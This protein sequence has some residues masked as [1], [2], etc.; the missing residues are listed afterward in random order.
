MNLKIKVSFLFLLIPCFL[1]SQEYN[2]MIKNKKTNEGLPY[3]SIGVPARAW[4]F[5][6]DENGNF[7]FKLTTEKDED[8]VQISLIGFQTI[9][10]KLE[11]LKYKCDNNE[12]IYLEEITY[13]LSQ[14]SITP[15]EYETKILGGKNLANFECTEL[16][17][18]KDTAYQRIA[19]EK[20]LDTNSIGWELGNKIK[21]KKGQQNFIDKIQFKV[22]LE[23]N[24]TAI[25]RINIYTKDKVIARHITPIGIIKEEKFINVMKEAVIVKSFGKTEVKSIDLSAQNIEISEDF[26]VALECIYASNKIM[27]IGIS[28]SIFGSTDLFMRTSSMAAWIKI[29]LIDLTFISATVSYKKTPNFWKRLFN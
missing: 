15:N 28:P 11:E 12:I 20:G 14:I 2:G 8:T 29:P 9:F 13:Q 27:K 6:S 1:F 4:G 7:K 19:L 17:K 22:C 26:I 25:Y 5:L 16:P 23:V 24:D 21:I 3:V 18:I 10:L